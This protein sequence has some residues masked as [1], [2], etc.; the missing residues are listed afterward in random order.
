MLTLNDTTVSQALPS[1]FFSFTYHCLTLTL[2]IWPWA[3]KQNRS[4]AYPSEWC[5]ATLDL[6]EEQ[7]TEKSEQESFILCENFILNLSSVSTYL[8]IALLLPAPSISDRIA[9]SLSPF[10][11]QRERW[12]RKPST[13]IQQLPTDWWMEPEVSSN[14]RFFLVMALLEAKNDGKINSWTKF[15]YTCTCLSGVLA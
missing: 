3:I 7:R 2:M 13:Q 12:N 6:P 9:S 15:W 10:S 11:L 8:Q 5:P 1:L 4:T 14:Q